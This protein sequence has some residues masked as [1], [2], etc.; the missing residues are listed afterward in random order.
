MTGKQLDGVASSLPW[1]S[2]PSVHAAYAP[3]MPR[4]QL[5]DRYEQHTK[6]CAVCLDAL[7]LTERCARLSRLFAH[8]ALTASLVALASPTP[9]PAR[10][11]LLT[12]AAAAS[13]SVALLRAYIVGPTLG[14]ITN[15]LAAAPLAAALAYVVALVA[16]PRAASL[17][18]HASSVLLPMAC[19]GSALGAVRAL[20]ALRARF[21][22]TEEAKA[23]QDSE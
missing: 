15:T 9:P 17:A 4:T 12:A 16:L 10:L 22:Y 6:H 21:V 2:A 8:A 5:L 3:P 18:L 19:A 13:Y 20:E 7:A 14:A 1:R 11:G 23:L